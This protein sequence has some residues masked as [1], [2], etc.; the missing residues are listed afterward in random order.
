MVDVKVYYRQGVC[1]TP[2]DNGKYQSLLRSTSMGSHPLLMV[3][4]KVYFGQ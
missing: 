3:D 1:I 4:V 2:F